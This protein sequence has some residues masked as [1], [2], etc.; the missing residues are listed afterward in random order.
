M[1]SPPPKQKVTYN[2]PGHAHFLT[3][4]C[5]RRLPLLS[6]DRSRTWVVEV[7][8][9]VRQKMDVTAQAVYSNLGAGRPAR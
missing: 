9:R 1:N 3:Y 5:Y 4:S 7:L 8:Q 2:M 6:V